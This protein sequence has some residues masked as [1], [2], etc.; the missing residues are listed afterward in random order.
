MEKKIKIIA[1]IAATVGIVLIVIAAVLFINAKNFQAKAVAVEGLVTELREM[2]NTTNQ[3][4]QIRAFTYAPVIKYTTK[5]G[6]EFTYCSN[7]SSNPP[8]YAVGEKVQIYYDPS[9]PAD[10]AMA[11]ISGMLGSIICG[12]IGIVFLLFGGVFYWLNSKGDG[13]KAL[14]QNGKKILADITEVAL[15]SSFEMNGKSPFR[16][17]CQWLNKTDNTVYEFK[18]KNLWFDPSQYMNNRNQIDVYIDFNNPK[19]YF[20]DISF[21]PKNA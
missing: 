14:M 18:S 13:D 15:N 21:L 3:P 2:S 7:N 12:G 9:N 4:G 11:G 16:I 5:E 6:Q 19:K 17:H 20:M 1:G 8:A 10:A